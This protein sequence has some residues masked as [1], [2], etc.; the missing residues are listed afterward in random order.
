MTDAR[1]RRDHAEVLERRA[2]PAQEL[3]A[4]AVALVLAGGVD[5]FRSLGAVL[6]HLH[7][8][9]DHQIHRLQRIDPRGIAAERGQRI[10]HRG[11]IHHAGHAGE[12]L[13]EH[14]R[15]AERDLLIEF[16]F[17]VPARERLDVRPLDERAV[18]VAEQVLEED[19]ERD[20]EALDGAAG[21]PGERVEAEIEVRPTV[22]GQ[23]IAA[24]EAV[25]G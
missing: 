18:L 21:E 17:H 3:V 12:V 23:R 7:G 8:V 6:V 2:P 10:A 14:A 22:D 25:L 11:E 16:L 24:A 15:G 20:G 5:Q 1:A 4:L 19:A 9:V 13:Q